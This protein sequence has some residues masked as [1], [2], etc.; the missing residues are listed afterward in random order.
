MDYPYE[1]NYIIY[2]LSLLLMIPCIYIH[3]GDCH[4]DK[5]FMWVPSIWIT[6]PYTLVMSLE[7]CSSKKKVSR[8]AGT[9]W[10]QIVYDH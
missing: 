3:Y 6:L 5:L 4:K 1:I 9:S 7:I 8:G 2:L 10:Y